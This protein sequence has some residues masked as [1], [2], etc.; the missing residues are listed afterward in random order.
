MLT[1]SW[2]FYDIVE[3]LP[4]EQEVKQ[5]S[6]ISSGMYSE[7]IVSHICRGKR[8]IFVG[9]FILFQNMSSR[10]DMNTPFL[11][12]FGTCIE[13]LLTVTLAMGTLQVMIHFY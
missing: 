6:S 7:D 4:N 11:T 5:L 10:D 12:L 8:Y 13:T 3:C 2:N 9:F 1:T